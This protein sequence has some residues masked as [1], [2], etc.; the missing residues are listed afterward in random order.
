M[1]WQGGARMSSQGEMLSS[2]HSEI[3]HQTP[4]TTGTLNVRAVGLKEKITLKQKP[5][6]VCGRLPKLNEVSEILLCHV[7]AWK[8]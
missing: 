2:L 6:T 5:W 8:T 7:N 3:G 4:T 1:L